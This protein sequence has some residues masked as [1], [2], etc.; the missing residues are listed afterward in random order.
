MYYI[1]TNIIFVFTVA[2]I[3]T[4]QITSKFFRLFF[5]FFSYIT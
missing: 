5:L 4:L 3:E 1:I 2:N